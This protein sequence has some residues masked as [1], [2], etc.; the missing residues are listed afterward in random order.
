MFKHRAERTKP[1]V[2]GRRAWPGRLLAALVAVLSAGNAAAQ[3][4]DV[5]VHDP[6]IVKVDDTYYI[7][8]SHLAAAR[9]TDL[10]HWTRFAE[11]VNPG[12]PLFV[13][14]NSELQDLFDWSGTVGLWANDVRQLDDGRFYMYPNLS[15]NTE[16]RA[17]L[18]LAIA[19]DVE[20][21]Y[22][23]Q[24]IFLQSGMWG[25]IS[26]DGE[27]IYE[28]RDHP[29]TIDP[30][31]FNDR[32]GELWMVYGSYSG[33]IFI[34]RMDPVTGLPE[35]SQ[36]Y[37]KHLWGGNHARIEGPFML[38][39]W[40]TGYYYLFVTFGGLDAVGGYNMRV[41]RSR[42]PDG[43]F[44][45][46]LGNDMAEV[47]SDPLLPLFDDASIE[48][49]GQKLMGNFRFRRKDGEP[50]AG[51]G[52]GYVSPGHN[53]AIYEPALD[54]YFLVFH[55]RFPNQG[56]FHQV[57]V[58][59]FF[60]NA[61][62]WP[63]VAPHRYLPESGPGSL[64]FRAEDASMTSFPPRKGLADPREQGACDQA[65]HCKPAPTRSAAELAGDYKFINHGKA[66]SSTIIESTLLVLN[67]NGSL[68]GAHT[69]RWASQPGDRLVL[70]IDEV[71]LFQGVVSR[72]WN[73][74][75][76]QYVMTF[77]AQSV[78]G[79]SVWGSRIEYEGGE[80][81]NQPNTAALPRVHNGMLVNKRLIKQ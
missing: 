76:D 51:S 14:P 18:S 3:F 35:P 48:P 16:P 58:H 77:T 6:S 78:E 60:L 13:N 67:A 79:I 12:N 20:G 29:N 61:D 27:N 38:Y 54:K 71:G 66:I 28:P 73:E 2:P 57:R 23:Y 47:K 11:G 32:S 39:S 56:E 69:G 15:A 37:G 81:N 46:A 45:D 10:V 4:T 22:T 31:V 21:P 36:G 8:G 52:H 64:G 30:H 68:G 33:G 44:L 65:R 53:S 62:G 40:D 17:S 59:E 19:D 24:E 41:A 34:L 55:T 63:V 75:A 25:E 70:D 1:N 7:F 80:S 43:P 50:G 74:T 26:E 72:G 5:T 49:F 42:R 9:S